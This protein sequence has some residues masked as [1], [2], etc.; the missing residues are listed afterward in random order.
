MA[1]AAF[2]TFIMLLARAIKHFS[3]NLCLPMSFVEENMKRAQ[4]VDACRKQR[5]YWRKNIFPQGFSLS[6]DLP[7]SGCDRRYEMNDDEASVEQLTIREIFEG[8]GD[9]C[10]LIPVVHKYLRVAVAHDCADNHRGQMDVANGC[11]VDQTASETSVFNVLCSQV[12]FIAKRV[13]GQLPTFAQSLRRF[14]HLHPEYKQDSLISD[15]IAYDICLLAL[16]IARDE[17]SESEVTENYDFF[18]KLQSFSP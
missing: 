11:L 13:S 15:S 3:L 18:A 14:I 9:F 2:T 4:S 17:I 6:D 10:G 8:C 5:F 12:D 7:N 16:A 1:N